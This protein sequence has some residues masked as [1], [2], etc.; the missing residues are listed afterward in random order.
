MR[1][2]AGRGRLGTEHA[3]QAQRVEV[4]RVGERQHVQPGARERLEHA[5]LV[6]PR[7]R[8]EQ[9]RELSVQ[10]AYELRVERERGRPRRPD[11]GALHD[12]RKHAREHDDD[13]V[14]AELHRPRARDA[15]WLCAISPTTIA[16]RLPRAP[17]TSGR[18]PA[19]ASAPG[20]A[21]SS[22]CSRGAA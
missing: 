14:V 20:R 17:E 16:V 18:A 22:I 6:G 7:E 11:S 3:E 12:R 10:V 2:R 9:P 19:T 13:E 21:T 5:G 4:E 15:A 8:R 1:E